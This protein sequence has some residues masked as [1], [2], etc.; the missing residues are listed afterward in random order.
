MPVRPRALP[1]YYVKNSNPFRYAFGDRRVRVKTLASD[2]PQIDLI[3][4]LAHS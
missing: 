3:N 4:G 2:L 1:T